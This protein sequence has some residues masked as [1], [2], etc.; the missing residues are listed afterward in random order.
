MATSSDRATLPPWPVVEYLPVTITWVAL[1]Y[2]VVGVDTD[3]LR[4]ASGLVLPI[5]VGIGLWRQGR[6][7]WWIGIALSV[8]AIVLGALSLFGGG[9]SVGAVQVLGG[10]CS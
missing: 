3:V 2:L 9:A 10:G 7:A 1:F 8:L 4:V 5:A 6:F